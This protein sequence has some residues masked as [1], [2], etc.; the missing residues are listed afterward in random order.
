MYVLL[1]QVYDEYEAREVI[2]VL[3]TTLEFVHEKGIV[4]RDLKYVLVG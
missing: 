1:W 2:K 4:H 3:L